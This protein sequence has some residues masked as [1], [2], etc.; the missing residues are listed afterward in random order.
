MKIHYYLFSSLL[1][2]IRNSMEVAT[3][4]FQTV[5]NNNYLLVREIQQPVLTVKFL[6]YEQLG[7]VCLSRHCLL[8]YEAQW[9]LT[10]DPALCSILCAIDHHK[11]GLWCQRQ[12]SKKG[13]SICIPQYSVRCNYLSITEIPASGTKVLK[14]AYKRRLY[15][16]T[17]TVNHII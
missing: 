15:P 17:N 3:D 7:N 8:I 14:Y 4:T 1:L 13:I 11:R 12:A 2:V 10:P 6:K 9:K 16:N 5:I